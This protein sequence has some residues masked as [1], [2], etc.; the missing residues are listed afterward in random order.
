MLTRIFKTLKAGLK[1]IIDECQTAQ[2]QPDTSIL[3]RPVSLVSQRR[4][5]SAIAQFIGY[6]VESE[7]AGGRIDETEH[8]F[9][10]GYYDDV[11]ITTHYYENNLL[12]S[13]FST[14]HEGGHAIYEQNLKPD[15]MYQPVGASCSLGFHESQ[16]RLVENIIGR[17]P[18]FW[19]SFLPKLKDLT[20]NIFSDVELNP[21][22]FAINR[23]QPSKIRIEA[24][25]VTYGLHIIIRF[26]IEC[27]LLDGKVTVAELP[28][29]WNQKYKDY[30]NVDI[31]HDA[32]GVMQDTHWANGSIGYFPTYALGN[33]Y[34]GQILVQMQKK[35]P[36]WKNQV[37]RG[38]FHH[39]RRWLVEN[40]HHYGNL[41][42]PADLIKKITGETIN[43]KPYLNYLN[44]KYAM[45]Y[46]F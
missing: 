4:I 45:L 46:G 11:R 22:V 14:L 5:S 10:A 29:I 3:H 7:K 6:D 9:T 19:T 8:P 20:G 28:A 2:Q 34:S 39:I 38:N 12:S 21:F 43:S 31:N 18:E 13:I 36:D 24:D 33:I 30:L 23:V 42:D 1:S 41:Y 27:D 37:T 17:S 26:E 40:I 15:W 44:D 32:E 25:E 16:S 35:L